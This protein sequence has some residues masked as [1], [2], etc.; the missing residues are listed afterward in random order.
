MS[1]YYD[2]KPSDFKKGVPALK[3][4]RGAF[5]A[6]ENTG[7]TNNIMQAG[8]YDGEEVRNYCFDSNGEN[9]KNDVFGITIEMAM[10]QN[11]ISQDR[12]NKYRKR[13]ELFEEFVT[14]DKYDTV[15]F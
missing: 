5:Y 7:Y 13:L 3:M 15:R 6:P 14:S 2:L 9:G 4:K 11:F 10:E 1:S 12:I 8:I